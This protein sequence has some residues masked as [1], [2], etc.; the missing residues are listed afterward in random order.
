M[1]E[2]DRE[3]EI[4]YARRE[5]RERELGGAGPFMSGRTHALFAMYMNYMNPSAHFP[6]IISLAFL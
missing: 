4:S 3:R 5:E 1:Q 2:E 6:L